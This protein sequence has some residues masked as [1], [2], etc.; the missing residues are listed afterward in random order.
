MALQKSQFLSTFENNISEVYLIDNGPETQPGRGAGGVPLLLL[1][2]SKKLC[3]D[4]GQ[5]FPIFSGNIA[6]TIIFFGIF[7]HFLDS[8]YKARKYYVQYVYHP[9]DGKDDKKINN[10]ENI[11]AVYNNLGTSIQKNVTILSGI[12]V[13]SRMDKIMTNID[14]SWKGDAREIL[15]H[16][17][18]PECKKNG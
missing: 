13:N 1:K 2:R 9:S 10:F 12:D 16:F 11:N 14:L 8:K 5:K 17:S 4:D 18:N 6:W 7:L 3:T 15:G